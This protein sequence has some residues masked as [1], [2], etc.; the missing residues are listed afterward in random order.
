VSAFPKFGKLGNAGAKLLTIVLAACFT[1]FGSCV[2]A[3][4]KAPELWSLTDENILM[5]QV[6]EVLMLQHTVGRTKS[7]Q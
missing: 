7:A 4:G 2:L 6:C 5:P 3:L 1:S